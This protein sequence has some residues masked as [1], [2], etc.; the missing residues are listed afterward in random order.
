MISMTLFEIDQNIRAVLDQMCEIDEDGVISD[1][2]FEALDELQE[3]RKQKLENVAL[4]IKELKVEA[5]ALD[6]EAKRLSAR[7]KTISK[8]ME[9]FK[10]YVSTSM[11]TNGDK[12]LKTSRCAITFRKSEKVIV[13][14]SR[15]PKAYLVK[16]VELAPDK[17]LIKELLKGGKKIRGAH[18]EESQNIQIN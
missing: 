5:D 9:F 4:Y 8:R 15:I 14:E 16:K 3:E 2:D 12:E 18:L 7:A 1:A 13:D 17:R 11:I 6:A 10:N